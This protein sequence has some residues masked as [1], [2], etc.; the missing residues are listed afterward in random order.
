MCREL[1]FV[2]P[3]IR[4]QQ[5]LMLLCGGA[6][7]PQPALLVRSHRPGC[8]AL[9]RRT[10]SPPRSQ[11]HTAQLAAACAALQAQREARAANL[12]PQRPGVSVSLCVGLVRATPLGLRLAAAIMRSLRVWR[13]P[14]HPLHV[15]WT[16]DPD[17]SFLARLDS[18]VKKNGTFIKKL[19]GLG[20]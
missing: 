8:S 10:P 15:L 7:A 19:R 12:N 2:Y 9:V 14:H 13:V 4:Q 1:L 5:Q 11:A 6:R 3:G 16:V 20:G 17:E 18:S